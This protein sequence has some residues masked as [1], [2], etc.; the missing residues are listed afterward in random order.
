MHERNRPVVFPVTVQGDSVGGGYTFT[1]I[2]GHEYQGKP[3][4]GGKPQPGDRA[5]AGLVSRHDRRMPFILGDA[6]PVKE[7]SSA[8]L[9]SRP[10]A[11]AYWPQ[12]EGQPELSNATFEATPQAVMTGRGT[13]VLI[14]TTSP[15]HQ[16]YLP[17][18]FVV[19]TDSGTAKYAFAHWSEQPDGWWIAVM[20]GDLFQT[21]LF[22][23][24]PVTLIEKFAIS[25]VGGAIAQAGGLFGGGLDHGCL[26]LHYR[27]ADNSLILF[28]PLTHIT[29]KLAA[30]HISLRT[31]FVKRSTTTKA[32]IHASLG[33]DRILI[34]HWGSSAI[35]SGAESDYYLGDQNL[36]LSKVLANGAVTLLSTI[37]AT[38]LV[39]GNYLFGCTPNGRARGRWPWRTADKTFFVFAS[40]CDKGAKVIG[41]TYPT[42]VYLRPTDDGTG[43]AEP[44]T[45]SSYNYV[46]TT[47]GTLCSINASGLVSQLFSDVVTAGSTSTNTDSLSWY[48]SLVTPTAQ[49]WALTEGIVPTRQSTPVYMSWGPLLYTMPE[50]V[51]LHPLTLRNPYPHGTGPNDPFEWSPGGTTGCGVSVSSAGKVVFIRSVPFAELYYNN[52]L[53]TGISIT[54]TEYQG[55][56]NGGEVGDPPV[57]AEL[58]FQWQIP[59]RRSYYKTYLRVLAA[60]NSA[61]VADLDISQY[62]EG[63]QDGPVVTL[64]PSSG[65][66]V[67]N[68]RTYEARPILDQIW[69]YQMI[70]AQ[71]SWAGQLDMVVL[72]RDWRDQLTGQPGQARPVLSL[73][74]ATTGSLR[75]TIELM[76]LDW[77]ADSPSGPHYANC[78][79]SRP[80]F[81]WGISSDVWP[82]T[83]WV[84]VYVQYKTKASIYDT[85]GTGDTTLRITSLRWTIDNQDLETPVITHE[86]FTG[87]TLPEQ[88][89]DGLIYAAGSVLWQLGWQA[90]LFS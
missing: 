28:G 78:L 27:Q 67:D 81:K 6:R 49:G 1:G 80:Q 41:G 33:H 37:P 90:I 14:D 45:G 57:P 7:F 51:L 2:D 31:L 44:T 53:S 9:L 88:A 59:A 26:A 83:P 50:Q 48:D 68:Y 72:L 89:L 71:G 12:A 36:T 75:N 29:G 82:G 11:R 34:G 21:G 4:V 76:P 87:V 19:W 62:L 23:P 85:L 47:T 73:L 77:H 38:D 13:F 65:L 64:D 56:I 16:S 63:M 42:G 84:D 8:N 79:V 5:N 3:S 74:G 86:D 10:Y 70:E 30:W 40:G 20:V 69:Q 61:I 32:L 15:P 66:P 22:E 60:D 25:D 18:G 24:G 43:T 54:T 52:E 55:W 35:A 17:R 39:S 58:S 46:G